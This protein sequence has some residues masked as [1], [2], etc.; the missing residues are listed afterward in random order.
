VLL[1]SEASSF[2]ITVFSPFFYS[3][4]F[5][6]ILNYRTH[7]WKNCPN[8]GNQHNDIVSW[9]D[10]S[11]TITWRWHW[12]GKVTR[13]AINGCNSAYRNVSKP[14][15]SVQFSSCSSV[16]WLKSDLKAS[17]NNKAHFFPSLLAVQAKNQRPD[18]TNCPLGHDV[19]QGLEFG[20]GGAAGMR[21]RHR[22]SGGSAGA[23]MGTAGCRNA[24]R[25]HLAFPRE[26]S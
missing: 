15:L 9:V 2:S 19:R 10:V 13:S 1:T 17:T 18:D 7:V 26:C 23:R 24:T 12:F 5:L 11:V 22:G 8:T 14:N 3:K 20:R 4:L 6:I 25:Q 16:L 21:S